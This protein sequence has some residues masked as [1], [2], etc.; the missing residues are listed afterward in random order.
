MKTKDGDYNKEFAKSQ[1][2]D[3][4][5]Q[6]EEAAKQVKPK[7]KAPAVETVDSNAEV[8]RPHSRRLLLA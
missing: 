2:A 8:S 7:A 6:L 4:R 5:R 3:F 1:T